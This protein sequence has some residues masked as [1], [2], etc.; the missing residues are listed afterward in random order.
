MSFEDGLE[1]GASTPTSTPT[2]NSLTLQ[3]AIALG[4]Y[5]PDFLGTFPEWNTFPRHVQFEYVK[6]ALDNCERQLLVRW[7]E[8]N[9]FLDFSQKPHLKT[10]LDN[11]QH[12]LREVRA[13]R[14]RLYVEYSL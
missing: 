12:R 8:I 10:A 9:N 4:Q 14:E 13:D 11:L 5:D 2:G 3:S 7:A 6:K 1:K